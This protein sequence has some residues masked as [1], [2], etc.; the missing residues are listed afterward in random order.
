MKSASF[1]AFLTV[2]PALAADRP[3]TV[4]K[5]FQFPPNMIPCIDGNT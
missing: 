3:G 5:I 2:Y 1:L 4:F